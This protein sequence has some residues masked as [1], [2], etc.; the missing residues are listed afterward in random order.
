MTQWSQAPLR[1]FLTEFLRSVV[2]V[3]V[4]ALAAHAWAWDFVSDDTFINLRYARNL[5]DGEG[6]VF[7]AGERVEAYSSLLLVLLVAAAG[8]VGVDLLHAARALSLLASAACA[9]LAYRAARRL[10][11]AAGSAAA[12]AAPVLVAASAPVACWALGGMDAPLFGAVVL[13]AVRAVAGTARGDSGLRAGV[14]LALLVATRPEGLAAGA[15]LLVVAWLAPAGARRRTWLASGVFAAAVAALLVFRLVYYG[16]WLPNTYHAKVGGFSLALA[17]RGLDYLAD[18]ARDHGGAMLWLGPFI[19]AFWRRDVLWWATAAAAAALVAC[20]VLEGGDGLPM[21]RFLVPVVP[22]WAAL[23]ASLLADAVA[24]LG[25]GPLHA[26]PVLACAV[27]AASAAWPSHDSVHYLR[28]R[29]HVDFEIEAWT[30]AGKWLRE[31]APP[32]ASVACVPIG[33]IAY[34]SGLTTIDMLGLTD[35]HIA[36]VALPTGAGWAGHEKRDG[37]YV[38]SRRPTFL[39]L[40]NVRVLDHALPYDHPEFVRIRHPA[41]EAREGDVYGPDLVQHYE[42]KVANL[43]GGLFLHYLRRRSR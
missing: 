11:P 25:S 39:L 6:L 34:Y 7:N 40:G 15:V 20:V 8:A 19:A 13:L 18:F 30:A 38:L 2:A 31:N 24:R 35:A 28:Y 5:L 26:P 10:A 23:A 22:L 4:V 9:V 27:A 37:R 3:A 32:G 12:A 17:A 41:I 36:R 33:A 14:W 42:P 29:G 16:A 1:R 21:Y 43:G